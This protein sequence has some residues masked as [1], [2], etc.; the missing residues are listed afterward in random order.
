MIAA[1]V[2]VVGGAAEE[3]VPVAGARGVDVLQPVSRNLRTVMPGGQRQV[4]GVGRAG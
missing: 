3:V 4:D 2:V 1:V